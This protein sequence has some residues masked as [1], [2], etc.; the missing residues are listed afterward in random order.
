MYGHRPNTQTIRPSWIKGRGV[1][2]PVATLVTWTLTVTSQCGRLCGYLGNMGVNNDIEVGSDHEGED[3][4]PGRA[5]SLT[6]A[7]IGL[8]GTKS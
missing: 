1:V 2:N 7:H 5:P 6:V 4:P 8:H 3:V